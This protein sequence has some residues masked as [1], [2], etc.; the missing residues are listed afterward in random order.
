MCFPFPERQRD[1]C[2]HIVFRNI[3]NYFN[4]KE[5]G[6]GFLW[7]KGIF[8]L[9]IDGAKNEA[10]SISILRISHAKFFHFDWPSFVVATTE[11]NFHSLEIEYC[12]CLS[13]EIRGFVCLLSSPLFFSKTSEMTWKKPKSIDT[14]IKRGTSD[15]QRK[16]Q[17]PVTQKRGLIVF[18]GVK[19]AIFECK[20]RVCF[21]G[22][23][24]D[25]LGSFKMGSF[26]TFFSAKILW[27]AKLPF[28]LKLFC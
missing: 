3:W 13:V 6:D 18:L 27:E 5:K 7:T 15:E 22:G 23:S 20:S 10:I 21:L 24:L 9:S 16:D 26:N 12:L 17:N 2:I 8:L 25:S 4:S 14:A 11:K 19:K 28:R 1:K